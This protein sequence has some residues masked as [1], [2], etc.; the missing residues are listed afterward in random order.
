MT[1][2]HLPKH[3]ALVAAVNADI[4]AQAW[5]DVHAASAAGFDSF[6]AYEAQQADDY[7][8]E[9]AAHDYAHDMHVVDSASDL[10]TSNSSD[11]TSPF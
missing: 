1:T 8:A 7:E 4:D 10:L 9:L 5:L 6:E 2:F 3:A 11:F